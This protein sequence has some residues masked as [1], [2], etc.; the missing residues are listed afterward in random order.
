[1]LTI[2]EKDLVRI[3]I[4]DQ[5]NGLNDTDAITKVMS[6]YASLSDDEIRVKIAEYKTQKITEL[7]DLSDSLAQ[8][9]SDV[10]KQISDLMV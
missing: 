10:D 1:M 4:A 6:D 2:Q 5:I 7:T 9:K 3:I 8:Q